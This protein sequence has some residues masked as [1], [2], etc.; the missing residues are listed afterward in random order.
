MDDI[1]R[2]LGWASLVLGILG[3]LGA[4]AFFGTVDVPTLD[5]LTVEVVERR[6]VAWIPV[7]ACSLLYGL[8]GWATM[9]AL[10]S[11]LEDVQVLKSRKA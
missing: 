5:G 6:T 1:L 11:I 3:A 7:A 4:Y 9:L 10:A 8:V 2:V